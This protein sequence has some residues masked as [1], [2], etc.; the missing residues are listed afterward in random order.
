[1]DLIDFKVFSHLAQ[2]MHFGRAARSL[3]MSASALTRRV[4][5]MEE[6]L[7]H[8]LLI[9]DHREVRMTDAGKRFREFAGMQLENWENFRNELRDEASAPTGTLNIA[10]TVTAAHTILPRLLSEYRRAYPGVTLG[11][12]TQDAT[13]SLNQLEAGEVDLAVI[14]TDHDEEDGLL[15]VALGRTEFSFITSHSP[16]PWDK[17]LAKKDFQDVPLVAPIS[18]LERRR[19]TEYLKSRQVTPLIVAEVRGNEGIIAMVSLGA[20][21]GLVPRLVL[22]A[23]P[24]RTSVREVKGLRVPRGYEVSLCTKRRNLE[25]RIIQ[26]FW[27]LAEEGA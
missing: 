22:E 27:K 12:V 7:G 1:M 14:P 19:L 10:C 5:A 11:L 8:K 2:S 4:Q 3:G 23:S 26:L 16:A 18:G 24:L 21:V 6:E 25:R 20:G 13:R 9:R 17:Q 15:R